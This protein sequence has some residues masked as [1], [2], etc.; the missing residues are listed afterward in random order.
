[1]S[2]HVRPGRRPLHLLLAVFG[3]FSL[4]R[5]LEEGES[6]KS[7]PWPSWARGAECWV[8]RSD[9]GFN[10]KCKKALKGECV[11]RAPHLGRQGGPSRC[12][13][14]NIVGKQLLKP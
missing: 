8:R 7:N 5:K 4:G 10:D 12:E 13:R 6:Q 2:K 11:A 9:W 14:T 3:G 1:M